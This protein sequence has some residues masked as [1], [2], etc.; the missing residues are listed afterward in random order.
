MDHLYHSFISDLFFP[1]I[2]RSMAQFPAQ[3]Y[4]DEPSVQPEDLHDVS[5][6]PDGGG[7]GIIGGRKR[8]SKTVK[9]KWYKHPI[10]LA[11]SALCLVMIGIIGSIIALA[12]DSGDSSSVGVKLPEP[13]LDPDTTAKNRDAFHQVLSAR[14]NDKGMDFAPVLD[15]NS[16]QGRAVEYVVGSDLFSQLSEDKNVDRYAAVVFFLSTYRQPHLLTSNADEWNRANAWITKETLCIWEGIECN[17]DEQVLGII[18]PDNKLTGTLPLELALFNQLIK[19]ELSSNL[20]YMDETNHELWTLL[21]SLRDLIMD[22]NFFISETGIPQEFAGLQ[23]IEKI[24]LSFN[25]LQGSFD[26]D[27]F[28]QMPNL[29]HFEAESNYI[30]GPLPDTMLKLPNLTYIYLRSNSVSMALSDILLPGNLPL[31]FALWLDGNQITG[32][33]PSSI[34]AFNGIASFSITDAGL[35]GSLPSEMGLLTDLQRLWL[36]NNQL[37]GSIPTEA[38]ASWTKIEVFEVYGNE[39]TG[40]MPTSIC[41]AVQS[42]DYS[43]ATLSADCDEIVCDPNTCCTECY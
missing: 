34:G 17:A 26:T 18:L 14:Y 3:N 6:G 23:S 8:D 2:K 29:I 32:D 16:F 39:L 21:P 24:S 11:S 20:I 4:R 15:P 37:T 9:R 41:N 7:A 12:S 22:D 35:T 25:L 42:S 27:V 36:Y 5:L 10:F 13:D 28:E 31:L 30:Q 1:S 38:A 43:F 40:V 19:L 33:I